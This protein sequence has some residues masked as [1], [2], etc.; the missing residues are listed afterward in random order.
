MPYAN[1]IGSSIIEQI[2]CPSFG[3]KSFSGKTLSKFSLRKFLW[4]DSVLHLLGMYARPDVG[5]AN[6]DKNLGLF[7]RESSATTDVPVK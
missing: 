5:R 2:S 7:L 6:Q 1:S 3:S 4:E